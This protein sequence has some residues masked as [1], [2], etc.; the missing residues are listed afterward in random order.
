MYM[1]NRNLRC[2]KLLA[3][4]HLLVWAT[5]EQL[6]PSWATFNSNL[7]DESHWMSPVL[8]ETVHWWRALVGVGGLQVNRLKWQTILF[9]F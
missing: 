1:E 2:Y 8:V 9:I 3:H 6:L 4:P 5:N 7:T